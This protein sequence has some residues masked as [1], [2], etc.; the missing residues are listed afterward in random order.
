M[1]AKQRVADSFKQASI[2]SK[3]SI[4]NQGHAFFMYRYNGKRG[5]F[6]LVLKLRFLLYAVPLS[7]SLTSFYVVGLIVWS[8][9]KMA[10]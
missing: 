7:F 2:Q 4:K 6:L 5:V 9:A 1:T 10:N 8:K 3:R